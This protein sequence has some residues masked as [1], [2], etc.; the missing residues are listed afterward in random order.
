[1][2]FL[3]QVM[4]AAVVAS[5]AGLIALVWGQS[6][7]PSVSLA[8]Y[9]GGY[10]LVEEERSVRVRKGSGL[11]KGTAEAAYEIA[12]NNAKAEPVTVEV[13]ESMIGEW[14]ILSESQPHTRRNDRQA[15]WQVKVPASGEAVLRYRV[16][17]KFR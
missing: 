4:A 2:Q 3:R 13:T 9:E 12:L 8:I 5:T 11:P 10:A 15:V 7:S 17:S 14:R 16:R 6:D 1:M